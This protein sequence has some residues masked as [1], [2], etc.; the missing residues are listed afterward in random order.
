MPG[1]GEQRGLED[2]SPR[3]SCPRSPQHLAA[4]MVQDSCAAFSED[5]AMTWQ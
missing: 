5:G 3:A 2:K 1:G 4:L